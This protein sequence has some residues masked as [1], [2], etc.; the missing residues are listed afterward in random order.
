MGRNGRLLSDKVFDAETLRLMVHDDERLERLQL[1]ELCILQKKQG[2]H[3]GMDAVLLADFAQIRPKDHVV[4]FGT[5]TGI[6]PLLLLGRK[7]GCSFDAFEIQERMAEMAQRSMKLNGLEETIRIHHRSVEE[8]L[9]VL[10]PCSVEAIVCNPPYGAPGTTL[11]NPDE[12]IRLSR[13]Q[14]EEGLAGW[15][16]AAFRILKGKG[17]LSM[18][19]PAHQMLEAL[20]ALRAA[21]LVPK[22]FRLVYPYPNKPANLVLIEAVRDAKPMLHT[23]PP[24]IIHNEDGTETAALQAIYHVDRD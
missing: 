9:E 21:H 16:R 24:M 14:T 20:D 6:L 10:P 13:H 19:Y 8:A 4:D 3:Y 11:L 15:F 7:K 12:S 5:G 18:I 23:E 2:F 1:G 17:K 22:R